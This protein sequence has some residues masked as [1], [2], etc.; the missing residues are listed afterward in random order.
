[1]KV[2]PVSVFI[3]L[4]LNLNS[5]SKGSIT[6][7]LFFPSFF[8]G[9]PLVSSDFFPSVSSV[10]SLSFLFSPTIQALNSSIS[11]LA[12]TLDPLLSIPFSQLVKELE[13]GSSQRQGSAQD[14]KGK[15]KAKETQSA[16]DDGIAKE[17]GNGAGV[18]EEKKNGEE[19]PSE[20]AGMLDSAR[21]R[22]SVAYVLLDLIWSEY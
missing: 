15:G 14:A 3:I 2:S 7:L 12:E 18:A 21:M 5:P 16:E 1:M 4:I 8:S 10:S 13:S 6:T 19:E 9:I 20:L 17:K 22:V 11:K